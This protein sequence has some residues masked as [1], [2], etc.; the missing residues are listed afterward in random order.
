MTSEPAARREPRWRRVRDA[1]RR[2]F[3]FRL[4]WRFAVTL[5]GGA[6]LIAG[7]VMFATPGPGWLAVIAGLAILATEFTWAERLL[8]WAKFQAKKAAGR[9]LDPAARRCNLAIAALVAVIA[10]GLAWWWVLAYG[11]P[12]ALVDAWEWTRDQL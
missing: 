7:L 6:V 10:A 11:V 8:G 9:A 3:F 4:A 5:V 1:V 12:G 2:N